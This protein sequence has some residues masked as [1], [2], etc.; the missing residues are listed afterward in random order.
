MTSIG[1]NPTTDTVA[2]SM[3]HS[4]SNS[5]LGGEYSEVSAMTTTGEEDQGPGTE[6]GPTSKPGRRRLFGFGKKKDGKD[7]KDAKNG[8]DGDKQQVDD[9]AAPEP[10]AAANPVPIQTTRTASPLRSRADFE[11]SSPQGPALHYQTSPSPHRNLRSASPGMSSPASSSIFERNVQENSI[12]TEPSPAIPAHIQTENHIPPVL[13]A[14]AQAITDE[15]LDPDNVAI[16]T[17][18]AHQPAAVT[19]T[20]SSSGPDDNIP[21]A[22]LDDLLNQSVNDDTASN[23]GALDAADVRRLSFISFADVVQSENAEQHMSSRESVHLSGLTTNLSGNRS[24][25][26]VRSPLSEQGLGTSPPTS[27]PPSFKGLDSPPGRASRGPSSPALSYSSPTGELTIET[28]R[29]ALRKTGSGD[30]SGARSQ[31]LSAVS[32][33]D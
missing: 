2:G 28:M 23:Y 27:G 3:S 18:S 10:E 8:K 33:D 29:Q 16:V 24:P 19:V 7:G 22:S 4:S 9:D 32:A 13:E 6:S 21:A 26:P 5:L 1:S 25:S 31:P 11:A 20:G 12:P 30:L 15:R 14:S 17:H